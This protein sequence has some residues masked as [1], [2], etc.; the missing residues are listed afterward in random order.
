[1]SGFANRE[2]LKAA[3]PETTSTPIETPQRKKYQRKTVEVETDP[4]MTDPKY[5]QA[6]GNMMAFGGKKVID[7]AFSTAATALRDERFRL[8]E[9]EE[10][11]WDEFFYVVSKRSNFDPSSP[12]FLAIYAIVMLLTQLGSRLWERSGHKGLFAMFDKI[13]PKEPNK[14]PTDQEQPK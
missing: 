10:Q 7:S 8:S 5:K 11:T 13:T 3:I 1:M 14:T 6:I 9:E 12:W 2:E 4:L